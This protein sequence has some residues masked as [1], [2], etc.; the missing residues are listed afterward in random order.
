MASKDKKIEIDAK[1]LPDEKSVV[2]P[3]E[4]IKSIIQKLVEERKGKKKD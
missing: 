3:G 1:W 4:S 2:K